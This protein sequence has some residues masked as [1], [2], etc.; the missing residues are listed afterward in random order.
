MFKQKHFPIF[1][2]ILIVFLYACDNQNYTPKPKS[3]PRINLPERTGYDTYESDCPYKFE[4][5]KHTKIQV[6]SFFFDE[7]VYD[8]CWFNIVYPSINSK[9][10]FSYKKIGEDVTLEKILKDADEMTYKHSRKADFI[11]EMNIE[12][13]YGVKGLIFDLGGDAATN[14]Q[15][16]LTDYEKHYLRG[17]LY[18]YATPNADSLAPAINFVKEDLNHLFATFQWE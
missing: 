16:Y 11:D 9:I 5:P 8:K 3:Y 18:F 4:Y 6:D 17:A 13:K 14:I 12:N 1:F 2:I 10:H 15:F 7:V